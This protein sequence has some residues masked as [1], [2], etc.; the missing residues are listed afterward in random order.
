MTKEQEKLCICHLD[1][2]S[3]AR[4][5]MK[6]RTRYEAGES[7]TKTASAIGISRGFARKLIVEAGGD[8][9]PGTTSRKH[10]H[11]LPRH[12]LAALLKQKYEAGARVAD[13]A[14]PD[15]GSEEYVR[16]LLSEANTTMRPRGHRPDPEKHTKQGLYYRTRYESGEKLITIAESAGSNR[17]TV[18]KMIIEA[19]GKIRRRGF[20]SIAQTS[21]RRELA[22]TLRQKYEAG[23]TITELVNPEVGTFNTVKKMLTEAGTTLRGRTGRW[24]GPTPKA[25][26]AHKF[27]AQS[28]T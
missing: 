23:A 1:P 15:I 6:I 8:V 21:A 10:A 2:D 22:A 24:H 27:E 18:T 11:P 3:R 25:G 12:E 17:T 19:G 14:T 5:A 16:V 26:A 4:L 20:P 28:T 9:R 13:L 7:I